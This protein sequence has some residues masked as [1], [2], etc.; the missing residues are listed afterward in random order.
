MA[1][2]DIGDLVKVSASFANGSGTLID[3]TTVNF[4]YKMPDGTT[5]SYAYGADAE[6]VK[7]DTG[8]YH[9]NLQTGSVAGLYRYRFW[10]GSSGTGQA[11]G[12]AY[13]QV[14]RTHI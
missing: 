2:Y 5:G 12:E 1:V 6:L 9:V 11:A 3:P 13:F 4:S 10:S 7:D 8:M 14:A